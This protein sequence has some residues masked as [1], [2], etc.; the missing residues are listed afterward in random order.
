MADLPSTARRPRRL[1]TAVI[2]GLVDRLASGALT[3]GEALP[4]EPVLCESFDVSRTVV[5]EAVKALEAMG[6]VSVQQGQGTT[7]RSLAEWDLTNPTVL[8]AVVRHDAESSILEDVVAVRRALESQMARQAAEHADAAL[9]ATISERMAELT[10]ALGDKYAY[11]TAD[12]AFHDAIMA[13]SGNRLGRAI[14]RNVQVEAYRSL[15]YVGGSSP[16]HLRLTHETHQ[17]VHDAVVAGHG[18]LAERLMDEHIRDSWVRRRPL[19]ATRL[20]T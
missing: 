15:R 20:S 17:A 8:A 14:V 3:A 18:A 4:T 9:K 12:I 16:E 1:A 10:A 11:F 19:D 5:R 2:D 7:V 13:G 6:M